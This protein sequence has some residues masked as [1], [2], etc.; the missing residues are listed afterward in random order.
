MSGEAGHCR[1]FLDGYVFVDSDGDF[2]VTRSDMITCVAEFTLAIFLLIRIL[3]NR[4]RVQN[5]VDI[6][7]M[8]TLVFPQ[9]VY[10]LTTYAVVLFGAAV[11]QITLNVPTVQGDVEIST[12]WALSW[13]GFR[14]SECVTFCLLERGFGMLEIRRV[15]WRTGLLGMFTFALLFIRYYFNEQRIEFIFSA[16]MLSFYLYCLVLAPYWSSP[17]PALK[18]WAGFWVVFRVLIL[19]GFFFESDLSVCLFS[20]WQILGLGVMAPFMTYWALVSDMRY[21]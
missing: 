6:V 21:P 1:D 3:I 16:L 12:A 8:E 10:I 18:Y 20:V 17:R 9:Y 5:G 15:L 11:I 2:T 4:C 7:A 13:M 19:S 14:I